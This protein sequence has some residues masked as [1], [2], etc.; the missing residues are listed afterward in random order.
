[1]DYVLNNKKCQKKFPPISHNIY[2]QYH[3]SI[4]RNIYKRDHRSISHLETVEGGH[5]GVKQL[6]SGHDAV[7]QVVVAGKQNLICF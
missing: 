7:V 5:A 2:K 4:Y 3:Q 6:A 1:M